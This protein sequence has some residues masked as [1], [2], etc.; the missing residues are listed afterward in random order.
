M[1]VQARTLE[2]YG[3]YG[4][5]SEVIEQGVIAET[6]HVREGGSDGSR[7]V[8]SIS[9]KE[10]GAGLTPYPFALAY[11]QD[12]HER[13]LIGK[14]EEAGCRVEW[15]TKLTGFIEVPCVLP[16]IALKILG[17]VSEAKSEPRRVRF[18]GLIYALGVM[19]SFMALA[20]LVIGL[21]AAGHHVGW[22]VQFGNPIFLASLRSSPSSPSIFLASL[23]S[24]SAAGP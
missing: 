14:L 23:K 8:L 18:L 3:Q 17:F 12:D 5:A 20:A 7:E 16:V 15:E 19:L 13:F 21:K 1:V 24:P 22:G 6:A 10:M 9:F 11:A 2:F 4:F